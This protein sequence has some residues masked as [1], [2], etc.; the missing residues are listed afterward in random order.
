MKNSTVLAIVGGAVV[1]I[2][3]A[4][5]FGLRNTQPPVMP[6]VKTVESTTNPRVA[7]NTISALLDDAQTV[8]LA[9]DEALQNS[10]YGDIAEHASQIESLAQKIR[11]A[12]VTLSDFEIIS[13]DVSEIQHAADELGD[14][15][16]QRKREE[17]QH[18]GEK[19]KRFLDI[20]EKDI[21]NIRR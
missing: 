8:Y 9:L 19:L 20:L 3:I 13:R 5:F 10:N 7:I 2:A 4:I 11:Q 21:Q 15:S 1:L 12:A 14:A 17:I 18:A 16:K 6:M